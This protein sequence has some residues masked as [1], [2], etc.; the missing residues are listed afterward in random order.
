MS[1]LCQR[2]VLNTGGNAGFFIGKYAARFRPDAEYGGVNVRA[3]GPNGNAILDSDVAGGG[4][5]EQGGEAIGECERETV[6]AVRQCRCEFL[7]VRHG[8][9]LTAQS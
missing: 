8:V 3:A 9:N 6:P 1:D 7:D 4:G 2:P 5:I